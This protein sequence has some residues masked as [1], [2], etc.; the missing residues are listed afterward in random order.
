M[1]RKWRQ[2][3]SGAPT[4][5]VDTVEEAEKIITDHEIQTTNRY[6]VFRRNKGFTD[7]INC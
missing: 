4:V 3:V 2:S 6:T 1:V 5:V 7:D